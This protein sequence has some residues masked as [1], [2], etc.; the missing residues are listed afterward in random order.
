M[1]EY[2]DETS[3]KILQNFR[4]EF[5]GPILVDVSEVFPLYIKTILEEGAD[6]I[7]VDTEKV[8][9]NERYRG[10]HAIAVIYDARNAI[11]DYYKGREENDDR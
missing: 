6:G 7:I 1:L 10:K 3:L 4:K 11:N 2:K 8:T 5:D 9:K